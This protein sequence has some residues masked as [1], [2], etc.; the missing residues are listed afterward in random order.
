M[1]PSRKKSSAANG[2]TDGSLDMAEK[3]SFVRRKASP[4]KAIPTRSL[5]EDGDSSAS[6]GEDSDDG[7]AQLT[8]FKINEEYARRFEHNKKREERQR[9]EYLSTYPKLLRVQDVSS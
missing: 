3:E 2:G 7:G 9:C 6:S 5:F 1:A 8:G 4:A